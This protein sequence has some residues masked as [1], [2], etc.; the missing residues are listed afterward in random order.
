MPLVTMLDAWIQSKPSYSTFRE[1][2]WHLY[3]F[4]LFQWGSILVIKFI[5]D[6]SYGV[7]WNLR[8]LLPKDG[9]GNT[10]LH[11]I[12]MYNDRTMMESVFDDFLGSWEISQMVID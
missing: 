11:R 7:N 6:D 9:Q 1:R 2:F 8:V 12:A 10:L 5:L 4:N 3:F